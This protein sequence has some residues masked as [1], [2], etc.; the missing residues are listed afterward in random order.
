M[1]WVI[2]E[3]EGDVLLSRLKKKGVGR[4]ESCFAALSLANSGCF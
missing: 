1:L 4:L 3:V 2:T